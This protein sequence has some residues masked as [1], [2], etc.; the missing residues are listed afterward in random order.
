VLRDGADP[1]AAILEDLCNRRPGR[2]S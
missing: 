2:L 1:L